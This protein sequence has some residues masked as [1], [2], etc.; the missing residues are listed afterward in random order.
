MRR[1]TDT[2]AVNNQPVRKALSYIH[3]HLRR[4]IGIDEIV[5]AAGVSRRTLEIS[6][7]KELRQSLHQT[8]VN[9]RIRHAPGLLLTTKLPIQ[10]IAA[11]SGFCHASHMHRIFLKQ[12]GVPTSALRKSHC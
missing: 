1:S 7:R 8:V 3:E 4:S 6:F 2:L 5:A 9:L 10:D 12:Y 11:Q